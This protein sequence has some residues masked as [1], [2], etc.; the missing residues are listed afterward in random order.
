[1]ATVKHPVQML[2]GSF[3]FHFIVGF[4]VVLLKCYPE[5]L[6]IIH[7]FLSVNDLLRCD[8]KL[9]Y[10]YTEQSLF[11]LSNPETSFYFKGLQGV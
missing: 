9:K 5:S 2:T 4:G 10:N 3:S 6:T 7:T 11:S 1:M 8:F